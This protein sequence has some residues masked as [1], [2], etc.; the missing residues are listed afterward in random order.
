VVRFAI[1]AVLCATACTATD[2]DGLQAGSGGGGGGGG[3]PPAGGWLEGWTRRRPL[4]VTPT[5]GNPG[6][7]ID[8]PLGVVLDT[9]ASLA[10]SA[11]PDATD[12]AFTL[13]GGERLDHEV[14]LFDGSTGALTAWVRIPTLPAQ[15]TTRLWMYYGNPGAEPQ[16][17]EATWQAAFEGVWH[18]ARS[19][20]GLATG[21]DSTA[22]NHDAAAGPNATPET[23]PGRAGQA[24]EFDGVDD[25][26]SVGDPSDESFDFG[27]DES[28]S[29]T[30]WVR[31]ESTVSDLDKAL[32]KGAGAPPDPGYAFELGAAGWNVDVDDTIHPIAANLGDTEDFLGSW[33]HLAMVIDRPA[34]AFRVY[35]NAQLSDMRD[36]AELGTLASASP[37]LIGG[38][39]F[40]F[41]G[42]ID[43]ARVI[44]RAL[45]PEWLMLE[46]ENLASPT[47]LIAVGDEEL[48][49]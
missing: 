4:T 40:R 21:R 6:E 49:P 11:N 13:E 47:E 19:E 35:A 2:L 36:I 29:V 5:T 7:L 39:D 10:A 38:A 28:F 9:D 18:F 23:T 42:A 14:E 46:H 48:R 16:A 24:A 27:G 31:V 34:S 41:K 43:E 26:F 37:L 45:S 12:L 44:R 33:T 32:M 3:G 30:L 17:A 22:R 20:G 8:F 15:G 25:S 1:A